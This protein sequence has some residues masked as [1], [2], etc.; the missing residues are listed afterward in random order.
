MEHQHFSLFVDRVTQTN[1]LVIQSSLLSSVLV[2][3]FSQALHLYRVQALSGESALFL[4]LS[5]SKSFSTFLANNLL[6]KSQ[7]K[8]MDP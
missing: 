7:T 4:L 2:S 5:N 3:S 1:L 8:Y 6:W